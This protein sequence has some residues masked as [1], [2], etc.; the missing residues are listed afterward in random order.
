MSMRTV[1]DFLGNQEGEKSVS[2]TDLTSVSLK[3]KLTV[4]K[5][6]MLKCFSLKILFQEYMIMPKTL[7]IVD[8]T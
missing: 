4:D 2:Y 7:T 5:R 8:I 1:M 3:H 6:T